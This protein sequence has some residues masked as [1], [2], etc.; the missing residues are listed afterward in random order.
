MAT[1]PT[2]GGDS[3]TWGTELNEW[4][5]D[6]VAGSSVLRSRGNFRG[7]PDLRATFTPNAPHGR[8]V[9]ASP[10]TVAISGTN[11]GVYQAVDLAGT[12]TSP[13][14]HKRLTVCAGA[15]WKQNAVNGGW[16]ANQNSPDL[17]TVTKSPG[18]VMVGTDTTQLTFA[19]RS[20]G[21]H[22][23]RLRADYA[24]GN[25]WQYITSING[26]AGPRNGS[27]QFISI[28]FPDNTPKRVRMDWDA[29]DLHGVWLASASDT[30]WAPKPR[31]PRVVVLGDSYAGGSGEPT[32][33]YNSLG[34][35][36]W[37]LAD[38]LGW[39]DVINA[40]IGGTGWTAGTQSF[41]NRA[42]RVAAWAPDIVI[43]AGGRNDFNAS[44][45]NITTAVTATLDAIRNGSPDALFLVTGPFSTGDPV[46][47]SVNTTWQPV[48]TAIF[49]GVTA[50]HRAL[51][52]DTVASGI[53][54]GTGRVGTAGTGNGNRLIQADGVHPTQAGSDYLGQRVATKTLETLSA[55]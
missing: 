42:S 3:G 27:D 53:F 49:A 33:G 31:G 40:G 47:G 41:Q 51:T 13:V 14:G 44:S 26:T 45:A 1:L 9:M 8:R 43:L 15:D 39:D 16:C 23:Y 38:T 4:L 12:N 48:Q 22:T 29:G 28:T 32:A 36:V 46:D 21:G 2:P 30:S 19:V 54:T 37:A 35:F 18:S 24:D 34:S 10:P 5:L 50:T 17:A 52:I 20:W 55:A 7:R 6:L 11:P 25:G